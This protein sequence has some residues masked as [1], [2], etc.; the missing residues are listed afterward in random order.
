[1]HTQG[2]HNGV[3]DHLAQWVADEAADKMGQ[4]G[5]QQVRRDA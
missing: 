5:T 2:G 4:Q 3:L 1:M